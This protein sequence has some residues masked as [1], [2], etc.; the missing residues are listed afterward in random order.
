MMSN[1]SKTLIHT[2]LLCEAQSIIQFLKLIA[3]K[4][5]PNIYEN[6]SYVLVVSGIGKDATIEALTKIFQM[7]TLHKA[8]NIGIAGCK[9]ESIAIGTLCCCTH[10]LPNIL[11]TTLST[12]LN[13]ITNK[14]KLS[15]TL[16]DMEAQFF[17]N[18]CEQYLPKEKI[19]C[20]KVVSDYLSSQIPKKQFV[21]E[22]I[23]KNMP[24]IKE[25]L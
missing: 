9:D 21:I 15:S 10:S 23:Q 8:I 7:Y 13:A 17:M 20:L 25:I 16:V 2:A 6:D 12:S 19:F 22:L 24:L 1:H 14:E 11:H 18:V 4:T 3:N 5:V